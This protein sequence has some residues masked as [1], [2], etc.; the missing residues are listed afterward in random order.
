MKEYQGWKHFGCFA[1]T[2]NLIVEDAIK[3]WQSEIESIKKIVAHLQRSSIS[4]ERLAKYQLQQNK[5]PK[6]PLQDVETRWNSKYYMLKRIVEIKE[7]VISTVALADRDL[8]TI[9]SDDWTTFEQLCQV[10]EPFEDVTRTMSEWAKKLNRQL[11]HNN[12]A[13]SNWILQ[14]N[15]WKRRF[16]NRRL[17]FNLNASAW[18]ENGT[19]RMVEST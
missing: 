17:T 15:N 3:I 10:L 9:S 4:S 19:I 8:P 7:T 14:Q 2:L 1:H 18:L 13:L 16:N 5:E 12:D 6:R 11:R